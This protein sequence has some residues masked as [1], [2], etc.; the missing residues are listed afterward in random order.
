MRQ[1]RVRRVSLGTI[2]PKEI[3]KCAWCHLRPVR[4]LAAVMTYGFT[5]ELVKLIGYCDSCCLGTIAKYQVK[6]KVESEVKYTPHKR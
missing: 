5:Y 1:I 3:P 6:Y 4:P 2:E